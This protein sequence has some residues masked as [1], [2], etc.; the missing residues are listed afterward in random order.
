M[1]ENDIIVK[2]LD[3]LNYESHEAIVKDVIDNFGRVKIKHL[4]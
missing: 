4:D 3:L 2:E 1:K